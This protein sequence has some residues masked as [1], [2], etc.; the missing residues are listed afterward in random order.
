MLSLVENVAAKIAERYGET[1][2]CDKF[3]KEMEKELSST[4]INF[5]ERVMKSIVK[6]VIAE[7]RRNPKLNL[8][9]PSINCLK[10][11]L[12]GWVARDTE[13]VCDMDLLVDYHEWL[14]KKFDTNWVYSWDKILILHFHDE[15]HALRAFFETFDE[16]LQE[17]SYKE[18]QLTQK[19]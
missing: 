17:Q 13:S 14:V 5:N 7:L 9:S 11:F 8:P 10:A 6:D 4:G 15:F 19:E 3:A 1:L 12:S 18:M 16:F 2:Q